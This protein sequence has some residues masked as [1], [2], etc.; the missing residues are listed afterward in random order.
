[1]Q[2][3]LISTEFTIYYNAYKQ[4]LFN[5][6]LRL[7]GDRMRAED[8]IQTVFLRLYEQMHTLRSR[9]A[10]RFWL[11]RA[12]RNEIYTVFRA[13]KIR[14]DQFAVQDVEEVTILS[15]DDVP[16]QLELKEMKQ[17]LTEGLESLPVEQKDAILLKE[18]GGFSYREIAEILKIDED[19]V[20]SR[21][22]KAKI[23]LIKK[24][25]QFTE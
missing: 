9:E 16:A 8:I 17:M 24:M 25:S 21:I 13:R 20:K 19:L 18:Y 12:V 4:G 11:F 23:K 14:V 2:H 22:H 7:L 10:V 15:P 6:A 5:Y 3:N 1:M